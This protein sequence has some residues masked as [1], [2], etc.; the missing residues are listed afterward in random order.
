MFLTEF[1][2]C[3]SV[4][5]NST[6]FGFSLADGALLGPLQQVELEPVQH[7]S[8]DDADNAAF[9]CGMQIASNH[10][11]LR[12]HCGQTTA[13]W[14]LLADTGRLRWVVPKAESINRP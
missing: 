8:D 4:E 5:S 13:S 1:S 6:S 14:P 12:Q 9:D 10:S 11:S 2:R 3:F 7:D